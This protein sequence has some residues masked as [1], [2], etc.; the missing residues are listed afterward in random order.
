MIKYSQ[1]PGAKVF[2]SM[3]DYFSNLGQELEKFHIK[4]LNATVNKASEAAKARMKD[5]NSKR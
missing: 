5:V 2:K 1:I 3:R 4:S